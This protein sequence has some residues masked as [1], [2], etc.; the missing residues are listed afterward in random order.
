MTAPAHDPVS[1]PAHYTVYPVQPIAITR[2]LSFC[3]GNAVK[4]VLRAPYKGGAEDLRKA[5]QYLIWEME[6]PGPQMP[7][8]VYLKLET[9]IDAIVNHLVQPRSQLADLQTAYLLNLDQYLATGDYAYLYALRDRVREMIALL[10]LA[11]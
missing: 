8:C 4:Y 3:L 7:H 5:E 9:A 11:Q 10:E 1:A 2:H 6:T